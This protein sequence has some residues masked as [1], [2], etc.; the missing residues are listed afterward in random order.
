[1]VENS[2]K[3]TK[4][5][6]VLH[7]SNSHGVSLKRYLANDKDRFKLFSRSFDGILLDFSRTAMDLGDFENLMELAGASGIEALR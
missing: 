5:M 4:I 3:I 2:E 7:K 6:Q 1:M